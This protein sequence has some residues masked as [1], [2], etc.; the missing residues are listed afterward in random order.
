MHRARR[1][2]EFWNW[3]PTFRAVAETGS[4]REA[5]AKLHV[6][7]SAISRTI[8]LLEDA[9]GHVLF[10]RVGGGLAVNAEGR[11]LLDGVRSAMRSVDDAIAAADGG[12][13][14]I[15]C[16]IDLVRMLLLE[17]L[18]TWARAHPS[19]PPIVHV[20]CAEDVPTQLLR[21][22]LDVVIDFEPA[23]VPGISSVPLGK[24]TSGVYCAPGDLARRASG[25]K[26]AEL[27]AL[28][29]VDYP[30]GALRFL[31]V[32]LDPSTQ[33]AA[34]A[35]TMELAVQFASRGLGLVTAPDFVVEWLDVKLKRLPCQLPVGTL[36]LWSRRALPGGA[37]SPLI[38]HLVRWASFSGL[39]RAPALEDVPRKRASHRV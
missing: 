36:H 14:H 34:Y 9:I 30:V 7:P 5:A 39:E 33:R 8:R 27:F 31:S 29:F 6:A 35:P 20:P 15:L 25:L 21:G 2:A 24:F 16:P 17:A 12:P 18:D 28:P 19:S 37:P 11:R 3:L 1:I 26:D 13:I 4:V 38:E 10:D 32:M 23:V 22:E